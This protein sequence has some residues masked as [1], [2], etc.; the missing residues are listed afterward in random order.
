MKISTKGRYGLEALMDMAMQT[1][2]AP[3]KI[4]S[5]AQRQGLSEK[6]LEQIFSAL[7]NNG[8]VISVRGAQGGYLLA[9]PTNQITVREILT[10]LEGPLSPVACATKGCDAECGRFDLCVT[11]AFWG[12]MAEALNQTTEAIVLSDLVECI[13]DQNH[14][15][16]LDFSI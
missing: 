5:I 16:Q 7:K 14:Q 1:D 3:V 12:N 13:K 8:I 15:D 11:K 9:R 4:S 10:A 2:D 6:Y